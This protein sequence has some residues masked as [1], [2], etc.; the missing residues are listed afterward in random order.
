MDASE[1]RIR[2]HPSVQRE[3]QKFPS[4]D[5]VKERDFRGE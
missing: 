2:Y 5:A 3:T 4:N 1:V